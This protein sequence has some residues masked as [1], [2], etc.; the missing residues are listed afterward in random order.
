MEW[1]YID[2][3]ENP[4]AI[5]RLVGNWRKNLK[6]ID[7]IVSSIAA[8]GATP[9]EVLSVVPNQ[10]PVWEIPPKH[11]GH[12]LDVPLT[13]AFSDTN[14]RKPYALWSTYLAAIP[15]VAKYGV[16]EALYEELAPTFGK[17]VANPLWFEPTPKGPN[18]VA[19]FAIEFALG[20]AD[21]AEE[22]VIQGANCFVKLVA[23]DY[24][25]RIGV[26]QGKVEGRHVAPEGVID[27][28]LN[29]PR[30]YV[31]FDKFDA[32]DRCLV[33]VSQNGLLVGTPQEIKNALA[34]LKLQRNNKTTAAFEQALY[35]M[36]GLEI[37][38]PTLKSLMYTSDQL[39]SIQDVW[40]G[41]TDIP[42]KDRYKA[43]YEV[44]VPNYMDAGQFLHMFGVSPDSIE[45]LT[46]PRQRS[47]VS[48]FEKFVHLFLQTQRAMEAGKPVRMEGSVC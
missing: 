44:L 32:L 8:T 17:K 22:V 37:A 28:T 5:P 30:G 43:L 34:I 11:A 2:L 13:L 18:S 21:V 38:D 46:I 25:P 40:A 15:L 10:L 39:S 23:G 42:M 29:S 14:L 35:Q 27:L 16:G 3:R 20:L 47:I 24:V 36:R 26:V 12:L 41:D 9:E 19:K 45:R 33:W 4:E 6:L 1:G 31:Q 7:A 48:G